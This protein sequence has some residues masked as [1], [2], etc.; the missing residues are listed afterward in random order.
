MNENQ[1]EKRASGTEAT[2]KNSSVEI[3]YNNVQEIEDTNS[4]IA[5]KSKKYLDQFIVM[6]DSEAENVKNS[7]ECNQ[8]KIKDNSGIINMCKRLI[9]NVQDGVKNWFGGLFSKNRKIGV[10]SDVSVVGEQEVSPDNRVSLAELAKGTGINAVG[11]QNSEQNEE[12]N[13][14]ILDKKAFGERNNENVNIKV[15][16]INK[17]PGTMR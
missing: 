4:A 10:D 11:N 7:V 17:G 3:I 6:V 16:N 13:G 14:W 15:E 8:K 5:E 1:I 12:N 9:S 2:N